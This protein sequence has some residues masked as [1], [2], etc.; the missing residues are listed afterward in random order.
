MMRFEQFVRR[1]EALCQKYGGREMKKWLN[2]EDV[3][4]LLNVSKRTLQTL[5]DSGRLA[6]SQIGR[7]MFYKP[8]DVQRLLT[9]MQEGKEAY[10]E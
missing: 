4:L 3:C 1:V 8:Q 2:G 5:R 7:N 6:Y 9:V 10:R